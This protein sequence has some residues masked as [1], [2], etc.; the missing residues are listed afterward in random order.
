M[1]SRPVPVR[2]LTCGPVQTVVTGLQRLA[3][4]AAVLLPLAYLPLLSVAGVE[5]VLV[6]LVAVNVACLLVGHGHSP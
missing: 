3:F 4:W 1:S 6:G 5:P 2:K